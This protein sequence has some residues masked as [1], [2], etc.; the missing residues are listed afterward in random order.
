MLR[1]VLLALFRGTRYANELT[2]TDELFRAFN[3]Y[4]VRVVRRPQAAILWSATLTLVLAYPLLCAV[5]ADWTQ[6]SVLTAAVATPSTSASSLTFLASPVLRTASP[7]IAVK[8][9]CVRASPSTNVPLAD[10][11][12]AIQA[13]LTHGVPPTDCVIVP[14]GLPKNHQPDDELT[15]SMFYRPYTSS[16]AG[17]WDENVRQLQQDLAS[18]QEPFPNVHVALDT[19]SGGTSKIELLYKLAP[20]S[21][22]TNFLLCVGYALALMYVII[23]LKRIKA[24]RSKIGL[25]IAFTVEVILSLTGAA[26]VL[27]FTHTDVQMIP[28]RMFPFIFIVIA[29]ENMFRLV[30]ALTYT[31]PEQPATVRIG[32]AF[33]KVG[34]L[35]SVS[36]LSNILLLT[37]AVFIAT[38]PVRQFCMFVIVALVIDYFLHTT[39]FLAVLSI[40]VRRLELEDLIQTSLA[41]SSTETD[42]SDDED[43]MYVDD[44]TSWNPMPK[45]L[46]FFSQGS[47]PTTTAAGAAITSF[48]LLSLQWHYM[49]DVDYFALSQYFRWSKFHPIV[50][51]RVNGS[52]KFDSVLSAA[53][54]NDTST[55]HWLSSSVIRWFRCHEFFVESK[56]LS[57]LV[58]HRSSFAVQIFE[59]DY[60]Q[61]NVP[62]EKIPIAPATGSLIMG[63]TSVL[64]CPYFAQFILVISFA[65]AAVL[66]ILEVML[67]DVRDE[68]SPDPRFNSS[69]VFV[70]KDLAG[71]HS[72]DV[73]RVATSSNGVVASVG[74]DHKILLWQVNAKRRL[75]PHK[76]PLAA[77][78]WPLTS[79]VLDSDGRY[80]AM[81]SKTGF[82]HCWSIATS[83]FV[84]SVE[85]QCLANATPATILFLTEK[86]PG[87]VTRVNLVVVGRNGVLYQ[88][89]MDS[90]G[91]VFEHKISDG[92]LISSDRLFT[93]RLP[94]R[95]V[96]AAKDGS[97]YITMLVRTTWISQRVQPQP[98]YFAVREQ[99]QGLISPAVPSKLPKLP[100]MLPE[101]HMQT[102]AP[103]PVVPVNEPCTIVPLPQVG[104]VLRTRGILVDCID[105][106]TGTIVKTFQIASYRRGTLR[107]FH[108]H[109][110]HCPFCGCS[111]IATLCILYCERDSGMLIMHTYVNSNRARKNI[112]LRVERDPREKRCIGFEG[113][114]ERQH[115]LED[116]SG[117][118][119]TDINIVMGMRR[120]FT[121]VDITSSAGGSRSE[122]NK[123]RH[124]GSVNG[125]IGSGTGHGVSSNSIALPASTRVE[126]QWEGWTMSMDGTVST[127]ELRAE[128]DSR[129]RFISHSTA[130]R[131][132]DLSSDEEYN[133][134]TNSIQPDLRQNSRRRQ[135]NRERQNGHGRRPTTRHHHRGEQELLV[136]H[137]G[138]V[139]KLGHRSM[140]VGFGNT[141]KVLYFGTEEVISPTDA[142]GEDEDVGLAY[143]SRR[144]RLQRK[145]SRS[146]FS[147]AGT[148]S[149]RASISRPSG[150]GLMGGGLMGTGMM[151]GGGGGG[152]HGG[153]MGGGA[154]RGGLMSAGARFRED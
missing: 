87:M 154:R 1:T 26:A 102:P 62:G 130:N 107:A 40:D 144:R 7:D 124:R 76:V 137:L 122:G 13:R 121:S 31:K 96:S 82:V 135:Q 139:S 44:S 88:I 126:D 80:L 153:L 68:Q 4:A 55:M 119:V 22:R 83:R 59:P 110:Q 134:D 73:V 64:R 86:V 18:G 69:P 120:K 98:G 116:V 27:R 9:A 148:S 97:I 72:L 49:C 152:G 106:Q 3:R 12:S 8:Q 85:L 150:G 19:P 91:V 84:L 129:S 115:W 142:E 151:S 145:D 29:T 146:S 32:T 149:P 104:M 34:F 5:F 15:F 127:Y 118:E 33:G 38:A 66:L 37:I 93:P 50:A 123:P 2:P 100:L 10:L 92:P 45:I 101:R 20:L 63:Q 79:I 57:A 109:T 30:N 65:V 53:K 58:P 42:E 143:V 141:V 39:Y 17:I 46:G 43:I 111:T 74:L 56:V 113:V 51:Q 136:S 75:K 105:V 14:P 67:R 41:I 16:V 52:D 77:D 48:F 90:G 6:T 103:S 94:R 54:P 125:S 35:S 11:A 24:V 108:D 71:Y 99:Q 28:K 128:E 117:W 60:F 95:I 132:R 112:C 81:T 114:V 133:A 23:S 36:Y 21:I 89:A 78:S 61:V 140:V 138:P 47:V 25:F 70:T 147:S 131:R